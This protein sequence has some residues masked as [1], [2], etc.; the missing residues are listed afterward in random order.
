MGPFELLLKKNE[1]VSALF[2]RLRKKYGPIFRL[3]VPFYTDAVFFVGG[4]LSK[5]YHMIKEDEAGFTY[6]YQ[7]F[8]RLGFGP[9][10]KKENSREPGFIPILERAFSRE[11]YNHF[12]KVTRAGHLNYMKTFWNKD[13]QQ[14]DLFNEMYALNIRL[15]IRAF[16][17]D[18]EEDKLLQFIE[19]VKCLDLEERIKSISSVMHN[20][21]PSGRKELDQHW[22]LTV[23]LVKQLVKSRAN[24][25]NENTSLEFL[26]F[27]IKETTDDKGVVDY[28]LLTSRVST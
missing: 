10:H 21:S 13:I 14:V 12:A 15:V 18:I 28:G 4:D 16:I 1:N 17:G 20:F 26:D 3:R 7:L 5:L 2:G 8:L 27:L 6:G 11:R 19:T 9:A 24:Y 23:D 22:F 25:S